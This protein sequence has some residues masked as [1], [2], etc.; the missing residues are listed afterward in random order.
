MGC[1]P[2][3]MSSGGGV[4]G[5][6]VE[7]NALM[8][9]VILT[10]TLCWQSTHIYY[11][12]YTTF[13]LFTGSAKSR[14]LYYLLLARTT[15]E[16]NPFNLLHLPA[17]SSILTCSPG[18][19]NVSAVTLL[20][21]LS[22]LS[23]LVVYCLFNSFFSLKN[24]IKTQIHFYSRSVSPLRLIRSQSWAAKTRCIMTQVTF[25]KQSL[26][27]PTS[28]AWWWAEVSEELCLPFAVMHL[29][30]HCSST[31]SAVTSCTSC[32]YPQTG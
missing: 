30:G 14:V 28:D 20:C 11:Y 12:W 3:G 19:T 18:D 7:V 17:I 27:V 10:G 21:V 16:A 22:S 31:S 29:N 32:K 26:K 23:G 9:W 8:P 1:Y 13:Q 15:V 5:C 4:A 2:L 24:I 25:D 6:S